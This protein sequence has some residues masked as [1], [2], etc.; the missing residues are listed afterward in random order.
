MGREV[1][2][3]V[4][5]PASRKITVNQDGKRVKKVSCVD[6]RNK[7]TERDERKN[8]NNSNGCILFVF[9]YIT[10]SVFFFLLNFKVLFTNHGICTYP[11]IFFFFLCTHIH[12]I[13]SRYKGIFVCL[14]RYY[15]Y[16]ISETW[17]TN[18]SCV[19]N[20]RDVC[21][22]HGAAAATHTRA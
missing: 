12:V 11:W 8:S 19:T 4:P 14:S 21:A 2:G 5:R 7:C 15:Y 6:T 10:F 1:P 20:D 13:S 22:T 16:Y 18:R 17:K 3:Q 9:T